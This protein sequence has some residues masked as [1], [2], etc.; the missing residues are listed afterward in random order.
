MARRKRSSTE[1]SVS[2]FPFLSILACVIGTLTLMITALALGQMDNPAMASLDRLDSAQRQAAADE[3]AVEELQTQLADARSSAGE[4]QQELDALRK[5]LQRLRMV[6][7]E[8]TAE[9]TKRLAEPLPAPPQVDEAALQKQVD[10]LKEQIAAQQ[11][12]EKKLTSQLAQRKQPPDEAVVSVRPTGSGSNLK[13]TFVECTVDSIVI[14]EGDKPQRVRRGQLAG[15]AKFTELLK[16]IAKTDDETI[17]FLVR[18]DAVSTYALA[19]RVAT[20]HYARHGKIPLIGQGRIDL[21]LFE[22]GN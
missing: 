10:E 2:L 1:N 9:R 11:E 14:H 5:V 22:K 15:H 17:V 21:S 12:T 16:R 3:K 13:P 18:D 7:A 6:Q 4:S 19:K 20:T 8:I